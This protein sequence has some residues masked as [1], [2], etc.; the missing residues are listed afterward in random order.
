MST[1]IKLLLLG[2]FLILILKCWEVLV[3]GTRK[4]SESETYF[5]TMPMRI[6]NTTT[7]FPMTGS[8]CVKYEDEA[9]TLTP[10]EE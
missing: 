5:Y 4:C 1:L 2:L 3:L 10:V 7:I 6:G 9:E 8:Q